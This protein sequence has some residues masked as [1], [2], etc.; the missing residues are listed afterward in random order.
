MTQV[1]QRSPTAAH[2]RAQPFL[3][4]WSPYRLTRD[5]VTQE[6][7]WRYCEVAEDA[8]PVYWDEDF[9]KKT[10]FGGLVYPPQG[11]FAFTFAPWWQP[12]YVAKKTEEDA[13]RMSE[14]AEP[15]P[16]GGANR[17]V[18]ELGYT[19]ATMVGSEFEHIAP[20]GPGDGRIKSRS[21]TTDVSMEKQTR[22]GKGVFITS[23][24][25]FRT[26]VGDKLIARST[27]TLLMYDGTTPRGDQ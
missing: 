7:A 26:E 13:R 10:R 14:G 15:A 3:N 27:M 21:M 4:K 6:L 17:I 1:E 16:E 8:N 18:T 24:T 12:D 22:P 19:T 25:E 9:A 20:F 11:L 2:E 5:E 23:V